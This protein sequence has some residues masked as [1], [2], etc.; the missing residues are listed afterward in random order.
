MPRRLTLR[1]GFF[2]IPRPKWTEGG[3]SMSHL[4]LTRRDLLKTAGKASLSLAAAQTMSPFAFSVDRAKDVP[5]IKIGI[6][7]S[8]SG[9]VASF[10]APLRDAEL[11]AIDEINDKG[12]V[13]GRR[14]EAIIEDPASQF[15]QGYPN[16]ARKLLWKDKQAAS[17]GCW[18]SVSR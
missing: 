9:I 16:K 6:L 11:M 5:A 2:S 3:L 7:H 1:Q 14:I 12:G 13:L 10:E 17:F 18:T 15:T 8:L 4:T